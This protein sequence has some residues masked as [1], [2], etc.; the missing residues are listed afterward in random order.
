MKVLAG[1]VPP[2]YFGF[3]RG[4]LQSCQPID[5]FVIFAEL[6][7]SRRHFCQ[8]EDGVR[9]EQIKWYSGESG[10]SNASL[11]DSPPCSWMDS[12]HSSESPW[13]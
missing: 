11:I 4:G 10:I 12:R 13:S 8:F 2:V 9:F 1:G 3:D 7:H 5:Y 6:S